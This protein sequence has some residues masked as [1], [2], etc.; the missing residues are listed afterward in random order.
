VSWP[1]RRRNYVLMQPGQ[2]T[3]CRTA[4][5]A[6]ARV[7]PRAARFCL[8]SSSA[9]SL[10]MRRASSGVCNNLDVGSTS[11]RARPASRHRYP[12]N[13]TDR[14]YVAHAARASPQSRWPKWGKTWP[15]GI[16][17]CLRVLLRV[18]PLGVLLPGR[19]ADA[20]RTSCS[21]SISPITCF[22]NSATFFGGSRT[23]S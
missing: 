8:K 22:A 14:Q 19:S 3:E 6:P 1:A 9:R 21:I 15:A 2:R 23:S 18:D 17:L 12:T 11:L 20:L 5:H 16:R 7:P 10:R 13:W 4:P